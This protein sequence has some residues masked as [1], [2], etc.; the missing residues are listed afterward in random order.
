MKHRAPTIGRLPARRPVESRCAVSFDLA[1]VKEQTRAH[2]H[3]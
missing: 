2:R 1:M 3:S